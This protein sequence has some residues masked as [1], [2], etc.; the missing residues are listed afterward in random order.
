MNL[1]KELRE[2]KGWSQEHL[3]AVSGVGK[4]TIQRLE[5]GAV[6]PT[7]ETAMA[8]ADHLGTQPDEIMNW[9]GLRHHLRACVAAWFNR[10]PTEEELLTVPS[11]LRPLF[12]AFHDGLARLKACED[13]FVRLTEES[14]RLHERTMGILGENGADLQTV[15]IAE[16]PVASLEALN[17]VLARRAAWDDER[18]QQARVHEEMR[19]TSERVM[20][21]SR[22]TARV[23]SRLDRELD[24]YDVFSVFTAPTTTFASEP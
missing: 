11:H 6:V 5:V 20:R 9:S 13:A 16:D 3:A 2:R 4:R 24:A 22:E 14:N 18:V 19:Q 23:A 1:V 17:R 21:T 8:L 7:A 10:R 12:V 15:R